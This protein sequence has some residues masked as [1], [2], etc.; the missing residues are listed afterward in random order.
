MP[1]LSLILASA[2]TMRIG[3]LLTRLRRRGCVV[4]PLQ[5]Q[6]VKQRGFGGLY[7][8]LSSLLLG[9]L[10]KA[11]IRFST[12]AQVKRWLQVRRACGAAGVSVSPS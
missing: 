2:M 8:G 12:Y 1:Q 9:T 6:T 10:P 11:S 4:R 3:A 5:V 7:R